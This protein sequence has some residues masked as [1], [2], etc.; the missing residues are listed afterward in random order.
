MLDEKIEKV[1]DIASPILRVRVFL[2]VAPHCS[3]RDPGGG[4][5]LRSKG[6]TW[7]GLGVGLGIRGRSW[8]QI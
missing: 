2:A 1:C 4:V 5:G 6:W 7:V 3:T 8:I